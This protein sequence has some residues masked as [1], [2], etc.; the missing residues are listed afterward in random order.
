MRT[1]RRGHQRFSFAPDLSRLYREREELLRLEREGSL[2]PTFVDR[3]LRAVTREIDREV[4][5]LRRIE[6]EIYRSV[7]DASAHA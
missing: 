7:E 6:R 2:D 1:P 3:R 4:D 5:E